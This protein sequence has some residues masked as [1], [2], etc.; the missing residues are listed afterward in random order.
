M[1]ISIRFTAAS[2]PRRARDCWLLL[3]CG[4]SVPGSSQPIRTVWPEPGENADFIPIGPWNTDGLIIIPDDLSDAQSKY[5]QDL[6]ADG[7][8]VILTTSERPGPLIAVDNAGG[9]RQA[10]K[11]LRGHGHQRI[12]YIAG[13]SRL[14]GAPLCRLAR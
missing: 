10:F 4:I 11:H 13:K 14:G 1:T 2:V 12:A 5:L 3:G 7:F 8:P 6:I 9:I